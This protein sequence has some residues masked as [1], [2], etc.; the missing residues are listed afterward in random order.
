M[1]HHP[2]RSA[3][4]C[5]RLKEDGSACRRGLCKGLPRMGQLLISLSHRFLGIGLSKHAAGL[6]DGTHLI[7]KDCDVVGSSGRLKGMAIDR[8]ILPKINDLIGTGLGGTQNKAAVA[9]RAID[10]LTGGRGSWVRR[11]NLRAEVA[12]QKTPSGITPC[13]QD[14]ISSQIFDAVRNSSARPRNWL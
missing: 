6:K 8:A 1:T 5:R 2:R 7:H 4:A 13:G 14:A 3:G 12:S 11:S 10:R 9:S